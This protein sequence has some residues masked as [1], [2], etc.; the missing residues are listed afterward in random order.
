MRYG[1]L[2][3][4]PDVS[5]VPRA[6]AAKSAITASAHP[7]ALP[8]ALQDTHTDATF[9]CAVDPA[10]FDSASVDAATVQCATVDS[11]TLHA[12]AVD[13]ATFDSADDASV[14]ASTL[15]TAAVDTA[16]LERAVDA[17]NAH[18][19]ADANTPAHRS[20]EHGR[21]AGAR[22]RAAS[23]DVDRTRRGPGGACALC[24]GVRDFGARRDRR[25]ASSNGFDAA[26]D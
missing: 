1:R 7:A 5:I 9:D 23:V 26:A 22:D 19:D 11:A 18:T 14:D 12:T 17:A 15:N 8:V 25:R 2:P 16:T 3:R 24:T 6:R 4:V 13:A 20:G 10:T 21:I